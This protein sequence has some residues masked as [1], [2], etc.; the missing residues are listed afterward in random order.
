MRI[1][2][3]GCL[4]LR[5][6]PSPETDGAGT[7]ILSF[8]PPEMWGLDFIVNKPTYFV[9]PAWTDR[10]IYLSFFDLYHIISAY[11]KRQGSCAVVT[12]SP[13]P[14]T[15]LGYGNSLWSFLW[16]V[17]SS[18]CKRNVFLF[19]FFGTWGVKDIR[20]WKGRLDKAK[21]KCFCQNYTLADIAFVNI[22]LYDFQSTWH[23][24]FACLLTM[25][26]KYVV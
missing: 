11:T 1:R 18:V 19:I 14:V 17:H 3:V 4:Q 24:Y 5:R 26:N 9:I 10:D 8:Q 13:W 20:A 23:L 25:M 6:Q 15:H 21:R 16:C 12:P 7:L 2:E 22:T